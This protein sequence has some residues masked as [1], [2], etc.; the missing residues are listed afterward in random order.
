MTVHDARVRGLVAEGRITP[1][2]GERLQ[3]AL[4]GEARTWSIVRSPV[5]YLRPLHA[6]IAAAAVV[7]VSIAVAR[8]G[9]RFD[10]ALDVHRVAGTPGWPAVFADQLVAVPLT[11][12]LLWMASL[13]LTRQGRVQD[14][15]VAVAIARL[16]ALLLA[17]WT[18]VML[19]DPPGREELIRQALS[20]QIPVRI[21]WVSMANIP[22]LVWF[23]TWLYRGFAFSVGV[24]G[25]KTAVTF[26]VAIAVAE[27]LSK[28][29][30]R[31]LL[32]LM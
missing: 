27:V 20:G 13:I 18:L 16:P 28:F 6:L 10:G 15:V 2:E 11:A 31:A 30:L 3:R 25:V 5:E 12:V 19:P 1:E 32:S 21:M 29:A 22:M 7:A 23:F 24:R 9:I 17:V 14:F 8:W 26:T 4:Q